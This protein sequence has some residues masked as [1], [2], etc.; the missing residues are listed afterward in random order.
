[1]LY[2]DAEQMQNIEFKSKY[3]LPASMRSMSANLISPHMVPPKYS[4]AFF[5]FIS[6]LHYN[7]YSDLNISRPTAFSTLMHN[8]LKVRVSM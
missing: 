5:V 8:M 1:M 6:I 2:V 4:D 7:L 3:E